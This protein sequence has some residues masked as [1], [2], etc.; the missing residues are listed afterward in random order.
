MAWAEWGLRVL[1]V[2]SVQASPLRTL[3]SA[4]E[5]RGPPGSPHPCVPASAPPPPAPFTRPGRR[6]E[7]TEHLDQRFPFSGRRVEVRRGACRVP[8]QLPSGPS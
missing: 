7:G 4:R 5:Q 3:G 6:Q 8:W 1:R 2:S